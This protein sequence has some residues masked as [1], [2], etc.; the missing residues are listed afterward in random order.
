MA[1]KSLTLLGCGDVGPI[2]EP[3]NAYGALAAPVLSTG[4]IR[5]AQCER[6]YSNKGIEQVHIEHIHGRCRPDMA[7][8]FSDCHFNVVWPE[9]TP[10]IG[11]E[12]LFWT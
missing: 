1:E 10:W 5:F 7:S 8:F 3:M 12:R 6:V 4:D 11:E 9:I 2:H